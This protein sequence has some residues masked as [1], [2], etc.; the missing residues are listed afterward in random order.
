MT[1]FVFWAEIS[2]TKPMEQIL[3]LRGLR[4]ALGEIGLSDAEAAVY[5]FH[6]WRHYFTSYMKDKVDDRILQ[7]QTGHKTLSML[8][9][10]SEHA[11]A[12]DKAK[13]KAAQVETFS[14]L[15]PAAEAGM[16]RTLIAPEYKAAG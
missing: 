11:I 3:F 12:G 15:L 4:A 5:S 8:D 7:K 14:Q 10:Y 16:G 2:A 1:S 13:I 9:H 6:A